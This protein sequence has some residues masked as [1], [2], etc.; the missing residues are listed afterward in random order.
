MSNCNFGYTGAQWPA[1]SWYHPN[2]L[3]LT[4]SGSEDGDRERV[5]KAMRGTVF[6]KRSLHDVAGESFSSST[7]LSTPQASL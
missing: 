4:A 2:R 6:F 5:E 1:H 7:Q 3:F